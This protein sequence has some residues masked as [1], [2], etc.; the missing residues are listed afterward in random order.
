MG[1]LSLQTFLL[2][3]PKTVNSMYAILWEEN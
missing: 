2:T 3:E 1:F